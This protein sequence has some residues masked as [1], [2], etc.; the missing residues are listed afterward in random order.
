VHRID[1]AFALKAGLLEG[2]LKFFLLAAGRFDFQA[3]EAGVFEDFEF[4]EDGSIGRSPPAVETLLPVELGTGD[5][6]FGVGGGFI[7]A[8]RIGDQ[9]SPHH[10][11]GRAGEKSSA[12]CMVAWSD[13]IIH[14]W[15]PVEV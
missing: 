8:C 1:D 3:V 9:S 6:A 11:R 7:G 13:W 2:V 12:R 14:R 4:F 5:S 15:I 10:R